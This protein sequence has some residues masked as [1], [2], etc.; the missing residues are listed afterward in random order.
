MQEVLHKITSI[1]MALLLLLSTVS[2][3]VE[4][5]YCMGRLMDV[6][7]FT[8]V[9]TCGMDMSM[10]ETEENL[11]ET[12]NS[13]CDDEVVFVEGQDDLKIS[14]N[15][16]DIKQQ[17]FLVAFTIT[18]LLSLQDVKEQPVPHEQYPPPILVKDIQLLDEVFLI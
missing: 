7:L 2:W 18:Y 1:T 14:F 13:C 16:L 10:S 15:D 17:S 11:A 12:E 8:D 5:H 3:K 6:A 9:D 4:K